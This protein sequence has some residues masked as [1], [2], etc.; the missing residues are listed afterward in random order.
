MKGAL[1]KIAVLGAT[2][3]TGRRVCEKLLELARGSDV[4][5][6]LGGRYRIELERVSVE[7][8]KRFKQPIDI[9]L[10]NLAERPTLRIFCDNSTVIVNCAAPYAISGPPLLASAVHAKAHLVDASNEV[11]HIEQCALRASVVKEAGITVV[12]G[13]AVDPGIADLAIDVATRKWEQ[14]QSVH[15]LYMYRDL[16]ES[17]GLKAST[18][19]TF[20]QPCRTLV[21]RAL[22]SVAVASKKREFNWNGGSARGVIVPGGEVF[23]FPRH[24]PGVRNIAAYRVLERKHK[25]MV[26][27]LAGPLSAV[28]MLMMKKWARE[29]S[30]PSVTDV[31]QFAVVLEIEGITARRFAVVQGRGVY[32]STAALLAQAAY[33]LATDSPRA[34]GVVSPAQAF[35]ADWLLKACGLSVQVANA[36]AAPSPT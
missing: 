15:I 31:S 23:L 35:D 25:M 17:M 9:H 36:D 3:Y 24:L 11:G 12:N 18:L 20:R 1:K 34:T 2:G 22:Q 26:G 4:R 13:L 28:G 16:Q 5:L 29:A 8:G 14:V 27:M 6:M 21:D 7:L 10:V 30:Q 33:K 19:E 32:D